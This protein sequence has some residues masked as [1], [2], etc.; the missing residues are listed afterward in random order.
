M[1]LLNLK[2][3]PARWILAAG[4]ISAPSWAQ[5]S[6]SIVVLDPYNVVD[7]KEPGDLS[8]DLNQIER[9]QANDLSELFSNQS[10]LAVGG[11][12]PVA[13]KIYVRGFEDTM[14]N[15]TID[16]AQQIGELYHHQTRLQFEPEFIKSITLDAG[17]G[18]ATNGAGALTGAMQVTLKNAF[19]LLAPGRRYG[20]Y[21]KGSYDFNG[22]DG[23]KV[24]GSAYS[25]LSDTLGLIVTY[26]QADG[27]NYADG[28]GKITQPTAFNHERGY[29]KLN[30]AQGAQ[31]WSLSYESLHDFGTYYERPHMQNFTGTYIL[32]D[33]DMNRRTATFNHHL[34]AKNDRLDL[35]TTLYWTDSDFQNNRNT[36]GALYG[37]GNLESIGFDLRNHMHFA[38]TDV[39]FGFDYRDDSSLGRQQA[40]PPPFWGTS[41]QSARIFGLYAQTDHKLNDAVTLSAGLRADSYRLKIDSGVGA[42]VTNDGEGLSPNAGLTWQASSELTLR[43]NYAQAYR[44]VTIRETFF[45]ALY[46][47]NGSLK[48]EVADNAELGFAWQRDG[49]FLRGTAYA[50]NIQDYINAN[51]VGTGGIWGYWANMGDAKVEGYEFE[52]GKHWQNA[53]FS[54]G[55]WDAKNSFGPRALNDS[56]LGL[57]TSIGRTWTAKSKYFI[58]TAHLELGATLR[59]VEEEPNA[60]AN[61]A[62][63]KGAYTTA[64]F[65]A[66]WQPEGTDRFTVS[67]ALR[68]AFNEYYYD[69]ATFYWRPGGA[70]GFYPGFP[71]KGREL[72]L[73]LTAKF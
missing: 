73:S 52:A 68:N 21:F 6:D 26:T 49:L 34:D 3:I 55:V 44:G 48:P 72:S 32:S 35:A 54:L 67:A 37:S 38:Q 51:Y 18:A 41:G 53:F 10:S 30:G 58:P 16:G 50:Q 29:L 9:L 43:A 8:L 20:S 31:T 19:D 28:H 69:H 60:I 15:V 45:N 33:H 22:E 66:S 46:A 12:S 40:T 36:T 2:L 17:A 13:Q 25:K 27:N 39:I 5:D 71:A 4:L 14:L 56:D 63:P 59:H 64:D 23:Y 42:G 65:F 1:S 11:G 7:E 70:A 62:P 61:N 47:H 24:V 57:G